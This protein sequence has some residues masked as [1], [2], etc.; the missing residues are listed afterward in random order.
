[1]TGERRDGPGPGQVLLTVPQYREG[2]WNIVGD[3]VSSEQAF[4]I[5]WDHDKAHERGGGEQGEATLWAWPRDIAPLAL[6]HVLLDRAPHALCLHRAASVSHNNDEYHVR[7]G[8]PLPGAP[9]QAP[10]AW[11]AHGLFRAMH[12]FISAAGNWD[13]TGCFHRAGV[14]DTRTCRLLARAEDVSR[15]NCLDRLA[16]WSVQSGIPLSDKALLVSAR[17][18]SS[19]CAKALR[20]GFRILVSRSAVTDAAIAMADEA[21]AT[22]IGFA[23]TD[24]GRF[25]LFADR[26]GRLAAP[27]SGE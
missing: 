15:H 23:R 9:P 6:G 4:R 3:V 8:A 24:E 17:M 7:I 19:L 10:P 2:R 1:M 25:T 21:E 18:T 26:P 27:R 16:G 20:A 13:G 14:F 5:S 22:L 11:D 12:D